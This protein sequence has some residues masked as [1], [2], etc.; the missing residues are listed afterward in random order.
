M[1]K[2]ALVAHALDD[3]R[4]RSVWGTCWADA[5]G[6]WP[7]S[8]AL[9]SLAAGHH[10]DPS[11]DD[12]GLLARVVPTLGVAAETTDPSRDRLLTFD[13][14]ARWLTRLAATEPLVV[15]LDDL[16]WA[17]RSS[18]DLL[19]FLTRALH[20]VAVLFIGTA[21]DD[22]LPE[23]SR[24]TLAALTSRGEHI[25]I[26]GLDEAEVHDVVAELAGETVAE[27]WAPS[28]H[29]RSAGRPF[30]VK[31]LAVALAQG[32]GGTL[33]AAVRDAIT[34]RLDRLGASCRDVLQTA[35]LIG[36][37]VH[38]ELLVVVTGL[39]RAEVTTSLEQAECAGVLVAARFSHDL[40]RETLVS[41]Q[42]LP[43]RG[44]RH[45]RIAAAMAATQGPAHPPGEVA[46]HFAEAIGLDG[47]QRAVAWALRA[48]EVD[49]NRLALSEAAK[50]LRVVRERSAAAG[51]LLP[52]AVHVE[53]LVAEADALSRSGNPDEARALLELAW[54]IA[55]RPQQKAAVAL[56]VQSL[57]AR[58]A[59]PRTPVIE[60]LE[61]ARVCAAGDDDLQAQLTAALARELAHS[62]PEHRAKAGPL[63]LHALDL[64]RAPAAQLAC[65]RA[66]HDVL[67]TPGTGSDRQDLATRVVALADDL[68]DAEQ[69]AEGLL[70]LANAQLEQ[71]SPVFRYTLR[72][73]SDAMEALGQP[74]HQYLLLTRRAALALLDGRLDTAESLID[75]ATTLGERIREP[76][77][78][79]VRMS[80]R[81]AL[82]QQRG[83]PDELRAFADEAVRWWV[84][85]PVHAHAVAAGFL[86]RAGDLD[87]TRR[88][89][90]SVRELG[91]WR[92]DTSYLWSVFIG[93]LAEAAVA[94]GDLEMCADV[95]DGLRPVVTSC[96][97]NGAVV[98][99]AGSLS[100]PAGAVAKA[101]GLTDEG[102]GLLDQAAEVHTRLGACGI[103]SAGTGHAVLRRVGTTWSVAVGSSTASF[104]DSKGL[105]DLAVLLSQPGVDVHVL[106]LTGAG[107]VQGAAGELA[108]RSAIGAYRRRL[109]DLD[110]DEAVASD[111]HDLERATRLG[112]ERD[113]L[114]E[115]LGRV[116][117]HGGGSRAAT[118]ATAERAR[119][120]VSA[121]IK[122]AIARLAATMPDAAASLDRSV[123]TGNWCRYR[124]DP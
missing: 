61:Q 35:A 60:L 40:V 27:Q 66:R 52:A 67:W 115:E 62:I 4:P 6:Y 113:A 110:E 114:L 15:V 94:V 11:V 121:R 80:Q 19:D 46:R 70:L 63:S 17:D 87:A 123:V 93:Q 107:L 55:T 18:L 109:L 68:G 38:V 102:N 105:R 112:A 122:E 120:A 48:A 98:A 78:G 51:V 28:V 25:A 100:Q 43:E 45:L 21:R 86:S 20:G 31:E 79:N 30:F 49:R 53:L 83:D 73:W 12:R 108:D 95:L 58:F 89:L 16:Q 41:E 124:P 74:R 104:A 10:G 26:T 119:K 88:E 71:G 118:G 7:W 50:H 116:T 22:E 90:N 96:G 9:S 76:D 24:A 82:V 75:D 85:A 65:L 13:A 8:Q 37:E 36:N 44:G 29:R 5:P 99:F 56:G 54:P 81:L 1:G 103:G 3:L 111:Q 47:H 101:L 117:G 59:M 57:G 77:T 72:L 106:Q 97:V 92:A 42:R 2:S 23:S 32:A 14:I 91:G 84:G 69:R 33:P 64:A 39:Q 34:I